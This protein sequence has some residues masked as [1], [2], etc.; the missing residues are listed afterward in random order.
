MKREKTP[1]WLKRLCRGIKAHWNKSPVCFT[2]CQPCDCG[3]SECAR[4]F[5]V[6][7]V[8][9]PKRELVG[10]E[11]D[12]GIVF[13]FF[14]FDLLKLY[15]LMDTIKYMSINNG[16]SEYNPMVMIEGTCKK[17]RVGVCVMT[18]PPHYAKPYEKLNTV[19]GELVRCRKKKP[20]SGD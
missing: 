19:T 12:G 18:S 14:S 6:V 4:P 10:G 9:P 13:P 11:D 5:W 2:T 8:Y 17:H 3:D 16:A 15:D 7:D 20:Q 1:D